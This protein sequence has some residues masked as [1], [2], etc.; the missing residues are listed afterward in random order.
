MVGRFQNGKRG[1]ADASAR[2][3]HVRGGD[4]DA[5]LLKG[6]TIGEDQAAV[7]LKPRDSQRAARIVDR[8]WGERQPD[9]ALG[10]LAPGRLPKII[11]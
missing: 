8:R 9:L 1:L 3:S 7:W 2:P 10:S 4:D 5:G 11:R 6:R